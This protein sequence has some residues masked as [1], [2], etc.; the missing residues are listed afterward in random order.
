MDSG[1]AE[2]PP[3]RFHFLDIFKLPVLHPF[4][5]ILVLMFVL[6][7]DSYDDD[8]G[9]DDDGLP[10]HPCTYFHPPVLRPGRHHLLHCPDI[11][12]RYVFISII[13]V[14]FQMFNVDQRFSFSS[15]TLFR[16]LVVSLRQRIVLLSLG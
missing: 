13:F 2:P 8:D 5:V 12:G 15:T 14:D 3:P 9:D 7:V 10:R 16:T 6:Q 4:L 11:Q 1:S